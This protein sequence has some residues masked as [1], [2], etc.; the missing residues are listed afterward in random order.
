MNISNKINIY[1]NK[2]ESTLLK[3]PYFKLLFFLLVLLL[4]SAGLNW[5]Y[6]PQGGIVSGGG[7]DLLFHANRF[8][9]IIQAIEDGTYPFYINTEALNCYGYA[10]NLFYPDTM[11]VPFAILAPYIGFAT[12]Y[13][14]MIF[15]YTFL[16]GIFSYWCL[17]RVTKNYLTSF[18]FSILY[19]FAIYRI[20][21]ISYRGALGEFISFTFLPIVCLG[22]YEVIFNNYKKNWYIITIGFT[23]LIYTHLLSTLLIFICVCITLVI[24]FRKIKEEPSRL[25]YLTLAGIV[26]VFLSLG[27][28]LPM[29]EQLKDISFYFQTH[30]LADAI[31]PQSVELRRVLW[32]VFNGLT[33]NKLR[34][35]SIGIILMIPLLF[36]FAIKGKHKFLKF[37]DI[38]T[39]TSLIL[40]F[41]LSDIFPWY[42]FP[43]NQLAILQFPFRLL[44]PASFL[45]ACS[46]AIYLSIIAKETNRRILI[47]F[48]IILLV[49]Y[50]IRLTG[51]I[52]QGYA[53]YTIEDKENH[54]LDQLEVVG[55]EYLS[56]KI[57][58]SPTEDIRYRIEYI[59]NRGDSIKASTNTVLRDIKRENNKLLIKG[60]I[61]NGTNIILPLLYYK[62]YKAVSDQKTEF[63]IKESDTGLVEIITPNSLEITV[64]YNGTFIQ[65]ISLSISI[66]SL[67]LFLAYIIYTKH[68]SKRKL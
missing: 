35:E 31:G 11:L 61:E 21:D 24:C 2:A 6:F 55:A 14:L 66:I 51:G 30:P 59:V 38:C 34:I 20:I 1:I 56:S 68:T 5:W 12:A 41:A 54:N 45:L 25:I 32:G 8:Y 40:I 46:G 48:S 9:A 52:Y 67:F 27:F 26:S 7:T 13:K 15:C 49:G 29:F 50:S 53:L 28:L 18:L 62:G 22:L 39:F 44:Q 16:C 3:I 36:R 65:K 60:Q 33:D 17:N 64:W 10:A 43:F 19:T 58:S 23:C 63:E 4:L 42:T 57:P 47:L 37:A